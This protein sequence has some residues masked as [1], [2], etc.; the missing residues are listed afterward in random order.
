MTHSYD[1]IKPL[2]KQ[3]RYDYGVFIVVSKG[4]KIIKID[5][6]MREL[7]NKAVLFSGHSV[8]PLLTVE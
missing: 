8:C 2:C 3:I 7:E 5:Q 1:V 4:I 6:E